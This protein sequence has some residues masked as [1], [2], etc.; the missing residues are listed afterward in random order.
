MDAPT[1]RDVPADRPAV[2]Q[3]GLHPGPTS[4]VKATTRARPATNV[5]RSRP[6]P[7]PVRLALG[8]G[9]V[10]ALTVIAAGL[11][12]FPVATDAVSSQ[13][14]SSQS[15]S[16]TAGAASTTPA[17]ATV[18]RPVRY[19]RLKRGQQ[20]PPGARVIQKAA[21]KPRVVVRTIP[22]P[23]TT[24]PTTVTRP[25]VTRSRQSGG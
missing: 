13:A 8:A 24:R 16:S 3:P 15:G 1:D 14:G 22:A 19:V 25:T 9:A 18:L 2:A 7:R 21:P 5:T 4:T 20:A 17:S 11:V 10:A 6:D 23:T 12:R